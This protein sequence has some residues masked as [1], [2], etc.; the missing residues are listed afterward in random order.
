MVHRMNDWYKACEYLYSHVS[1][2]TPNMKEYLYKRGCVEQRH[3][4]MRGAKRR[5]VNVLE[6]KCL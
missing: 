2:Y 5:K 6:I 3:R 4:G 1:I